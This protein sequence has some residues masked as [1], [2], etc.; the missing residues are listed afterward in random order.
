MFGISNSCS[1]VQ[2]VVNQIN[3]SR[4]PKLEVF[5]SRSKAM[6]LLRGSESLIINSS[7]VQELRDGDSLEIV[8]GLPIS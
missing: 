8:A 4:I 3:P 5:N 7:S 2:I 1:I 6:K